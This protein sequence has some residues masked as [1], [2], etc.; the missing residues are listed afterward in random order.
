MSS[1]GRR[2]IIVTHRNDVR[3]KLNNMRCKRS[4][5]SGLGVFAFFIFLSVTGVAEIKCSDSHYIE[6]I[7]GPPPSYRT[8][9]VI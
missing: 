9:K 3:F 4:I 6:E 1:S 5:C 2:K 8:S 7:C